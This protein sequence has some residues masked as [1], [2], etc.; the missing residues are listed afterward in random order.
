MPI[1]EY[2]CRPAGHRFEALLRRH[3]E[4]PPPCP[5]CGSRDTNKLFSAFAVASHDPS[6]HCQACPSAAET[7]GGGTCSSGRTCPFG[8]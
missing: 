2:E 3:D 4:A 5:T 8:G 1:Y 7:C 6:P